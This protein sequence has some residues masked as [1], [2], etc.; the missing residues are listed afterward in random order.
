MRWIRN[1]EMNSITQFLK[2]LLT[3]ATPS[4]FRPSKTG[5]TAKFPKWVSL[6]VIL[7]LVAPLNGC[8]SASPSTNFGIDGR[9]VTKF[10][11]LSELSGG[12]ST[13]FDVCQEI[14][15]YEKGLIPGVM[16]AYDLKVAQSDRKHNL[17]LAEVNLRAG[18]AAN[19]PQLSTYLEGA[20]QEFANP[21]SK[22]DKY[23]SL[24]LGC[25][26]YNKMFTTMKRNYLP[27]GV[28]QGGCWNNP[29]V[30]AELQEFVNKNWVQINYADSLEKYDGYCTETGYP[31]A[32]NFF[33]ERSKKDPQERKFRLVW[34]EKG[35]VFSNG[36]K[37]ISTCPAY[38]LNLDDAKL[39][40][41]GTQC[42]Y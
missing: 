33:V 27:D 34:T 25:T 15:G 9:D 3:L 16:G 7:A 30:S 11:K 10:T 18:D 37:S 22:P 20:V 1:R 2:K 4:V 24:I 42:D 6:A 13:M 21:G 35:G 23:K 28:V 19:Y 26:A 29:Y 32:V 8:A 40:F 39:S 5:T 41:D 31:Y 14:D 36:L 12:D 17:Y 38:I